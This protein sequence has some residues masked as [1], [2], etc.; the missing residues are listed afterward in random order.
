M[1]DFAS[2]A[3]KKGEVMDESSLPTPDFAVEILLGKF[4]VDTKFALLCSTLGAV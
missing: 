1:E 2:F 4:G 3:R